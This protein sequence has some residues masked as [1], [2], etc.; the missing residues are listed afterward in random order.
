MMNVRAL[1]I[2]AA[3]VVVAAAVRAQSPAL[4][5]HHIHLRVADPAAAMNKYVRANGCTSVVLQGIGVGVR[6]GRAYLLFERNDEPGVVG[7]VL[8]QAFRPAVRGS[9]KVTG[10][11]D[12]AIVSATV[13]I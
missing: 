13:A 9:V 11:G 1:W 4:R 12:R 8:G 6:C 5:F 3:A 2:V 7:V 10:S